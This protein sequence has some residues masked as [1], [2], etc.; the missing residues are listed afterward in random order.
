M[1]QLHNFIDGRYVPSE[2]NEWIDV[3]EPATASPYAH[4]AKSTSGD[5]DSAVQAARRANAWGS[6]TG[7]DRAAILNKIADGIEN[8][9]DELARAESRDN[10][11]PVH[12]ARSID[13][14]RAARNFRFFAG[15][16]TH[17][18]SESHHGTGSI[19]YTLRKP[20]GVVGCISPWNLPLYLFT[21]KIA[22]A[23]AAGNTVVAKPSEVTPA[24]STMLGEICNEAGL[25]AGV[26]NIVNGYGVP[27]GEALS[28]LKDVK[29]IS[30]T[31]ST[32]TGRAI[33]SVAAPAFKKISL[34]MGGK[35]PVLVFADCDFERMMETTIRSSFSNQGEICLCGSRIFVED[36][37]YERFRDEFVKRT[38]NLVVG[39]PMN[40]D[41]DLG[42]IVS[43]EH[44]EKIESYV[45]L[46]REEGGTVLTGGEVSS[47]GGRVKDGWFFQPTVVE[48]LPNKCRTNQE[49]IFGPV[50]TIAPFR[51]ADEALSL[52]NDSVYG[53]A[54]VIWTS[55]LNRAHVLAENIH[56]GIV[57]VN[58]WMNRDLRTPF[59]GVGNSGVGREGGLEAMRFF[60]E[61]KNICIEYL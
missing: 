19:N 29:A 32:H 14:P 20:L 52:A 46:A 53:L 45:A 58:C 41:S 3:F 22:P 16:A 13:I 37:L 35:N 1:V 42:A 40:L 51:D 2:S 10:G 8:R 18:S 33:A 31:G 9:L 38:A 17:F 55:D 44:L 4:L 7:E 23:L 48:G 30:F 56:S 54:S 50:V 49:E 25:P 43:K 12:V 15:A 61:P 26:L 47:P 6:M 27:V 57:W 39:D 21:W 5:V 60:T 36:S 11:K 28:T 34:E 59:G 24:T